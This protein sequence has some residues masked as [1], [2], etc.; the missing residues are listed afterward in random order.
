MD[1]ENFDFLGELM[2][3]DYGQKEIIRRLFM[4]LTPKELKACRMVCHK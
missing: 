4:L 2:D 1:S 3:G